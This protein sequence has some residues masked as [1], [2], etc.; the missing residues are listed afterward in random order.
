MECIFKLYLYT[1]IKA[2][3]FLKV[4]LAYLKIKAYYWQK[5]FQYFILQKAE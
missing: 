5:Y 1:Y 4:K 2:L 3:G